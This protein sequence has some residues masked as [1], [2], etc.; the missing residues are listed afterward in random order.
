[1]S[2]F[3]IYASKIIVINMVNFRNT[4]N[5]GKLWEEHMNERCER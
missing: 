1:M 5:M 2:Y 3:N 4:V